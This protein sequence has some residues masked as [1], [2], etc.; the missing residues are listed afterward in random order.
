MQGGANARAGLL[1]R[2]T[3]NADSKYVGLYANAQGGIYSTWRGATAFSKTNVSWNNP[4]GGYLLHYCLIILKK[5]KLIIII[6][7]IKQMV[8]GYINQIIMI[9][10][11]YILN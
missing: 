4:P 10:G 3:L 6:H 1:I 5:I 8:Y 7:C 9:H 2:E 11:G